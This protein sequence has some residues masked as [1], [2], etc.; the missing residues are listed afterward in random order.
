MSTIIKLRATVDNNTLPIIDND[1]NETSYFI[2][3]FKNKL[4]GLGITLSDY[5]IEAMSSF[6][7]ELISRNL[8]N[9]IKYLLPFVG[10][11]TDFESGAI[12]LIDNINNYDTQPDVNQSTFSYDD[13]DDIVSY[14]GNATAT[15]KKIEIP[16][17]N[18][19]SNILMVSVNVNGNNDNNQNYINGVT[20]NNLLA[21]SIR[22]T[23]TG[24]VQYT[25]RTSNG[26]QASSFGHRE[27]KCHFYFGYT[28]DNKRIIF[29]TNENNVLSKFNINV[30]TWNTQLELDNVYIGGVSNWF[31]KDNIYIA[32]VLDASNITSKVITEIDNLIYNLE[33]SL[34]KSAT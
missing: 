34:G 8:I 23:S 26:L 15:S 11:K 18:T 22:R 27:G 31:V 32:C 21:F 10:T 17:K 9:H 16:I 14:A 13:D 4:L 33:E 29:A 12:P 30:I 5:K 28:N 24:I 25:G 19:S 1:G 6:I 7:D 20:G 2:G 3:Q